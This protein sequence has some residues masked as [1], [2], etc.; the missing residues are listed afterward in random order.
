LVG[1]IPF[2]EQVIQSMAQLIPLSEYSNNP[3]SREV[4]KIWKKIE[5]FN[6]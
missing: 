1:K 5:R 3:A 4:K 2:D 6:D